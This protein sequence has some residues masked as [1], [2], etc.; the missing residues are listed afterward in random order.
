MESHAHTDDHLWTALGVQHRAFLAQ[1]YSSAYRHAGE[2]SCDDDTGPV[3]HALMASAKRRFRTAAR[4]GLAA[5]H[6]SRPEGR[7]WHLLRPRILHCGGR[8]GRIPFRSTK[9]YSQYLIPAER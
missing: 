9:A 5:A 6:E 7:R 1:W 2:Q 4:G 3:G 8:N